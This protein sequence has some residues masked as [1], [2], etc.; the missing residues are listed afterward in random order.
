MGLPDGGP[1]TAADLATLLPACTNEDT[2]AVRFRPEEAFFMAYVLRCLQV[3][4]QEVR[5]LSLACGYWLA[6]QTG[7]DAPLFSWVRQY[8]VPRRF[9]KIFY[10]M[11]C[12]IFN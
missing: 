9:E 8:N 6:C 7:A 1:A 4:S 12:C 10:T 2:C 5:S 11:S 3:H